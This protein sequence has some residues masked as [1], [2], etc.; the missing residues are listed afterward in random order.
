MPLVES[1]GKIPAVVMSIVLAIIFVGLGVYITNQ[2]GTQANIS[3][4]TT[5]ST[6]LGSWGTTW[7]PIILIVAAAAIVITVLL[8]GFGGGRER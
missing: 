8:G 7:F 3:V 5:L 1:L 2:I 6:N 4:I